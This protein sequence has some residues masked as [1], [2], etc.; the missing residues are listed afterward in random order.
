MNPT[1]TTNFNRYRNNNHTV[2]IHKQNRFNP[3]TDLALPN[4]CT[5]I[6][7]MQIQTHA[8]EHQP[9]LTSSLNKHIYSSLKDREKEYV[10][11]VNYYQNLNRYGLP[12]DAT[13]QLNE[14]LGRN[15]TR[16]IR[17]DSYSQATNV[18]M[19][20]GGGNNSKKKED[21]L[22]RFIKRQYNRQDYYKNA[23]KLET[24]KCD[25]YPNFLTNS[26]FLPNDKEND[27]EFDSQAF[28]NM[29]KSKMLPNSVIIDRNIKEIQVEKQWSKNYSNVL[30]DQ[31]VF[32][33]V[34][35]MDLNKY[36]AL[37]KKIS[38]PYVHADKQKLNVDP[39]LKETILDLYNQI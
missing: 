26:E 15:K 5:V 36:N 1:I 23:E 33:D 8:R 7:P 32:K 16:F 17:G 39:I 24:L 28:N 22:D 37:T 2:E 35:Y 19:G 25:K 12:T 13:Q 29:K 27:T 3:L 11:D 9:T 38:S 18:N 21:F 4:N 20:L 6:N 34:N 14:T 10:E 31:K 30:N